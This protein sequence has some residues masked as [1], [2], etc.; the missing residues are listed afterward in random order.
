MLSICNTMYTPSIVTSIS[1]CKTP[2]HKTKNYLCKHWYEMSSV[3]T[4]EYLLTEKQCWNKMMTEKT[5][6]GDKRKPFQSD[7]K[8]G[9]TTC[10]LSTLCKGE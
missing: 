4:F 10:K 5:D 7:L 1:V 9:M 8:H 3:I 2:Q 6:H